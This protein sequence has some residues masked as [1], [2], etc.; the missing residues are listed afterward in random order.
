LAAPVWAAVGRVPPPAIWATFWVCKGPSAPPI[1]RLVPESIGLG[2]IDQELADPIWVEIAQVL[3]ARVLI[4]P[5]LTG[6]V[7][8]DLESAV[9]VIALESEIDQGLATIGRAIDPTGADPTIDPAPVVQGI[10]TSTTVP[11][12]STSTTTASR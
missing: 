4:G 6:R 7:S 5:A 1:P 11:V 2:L 8:I 9:L 12:G 3:T 10:S